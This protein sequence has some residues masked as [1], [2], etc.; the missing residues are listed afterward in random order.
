[1]KKLI[2]VAGPYSG[3]VERNIKRAEEVS[4]RLIR[5]GYDVITPHK[6]TAG[7]ERYEDENINYETWMELSLNILSRCDAIYIMKGSEQSK[8]TQKE[9]EFAKQHNIEIINEKENEWNVYSEHELGVAYTVIKRFG[10]FECTCPA[11][12]YGKGECKHIKKIRMRL[13]GETQ[14]NKL[15]PEEEK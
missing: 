6:N 2:Y 15:I 4:I 7:Y 3:D 14:Q 8:G 9:I 10:R 1:M 12:K 5:Q 11:F 13:S